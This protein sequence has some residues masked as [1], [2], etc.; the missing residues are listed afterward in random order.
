MKRS[1]FAK[2]ILAAALVA[3][4]SVQAASAV[5]ISEGS[6]PG[7]FSNG[8]ATPTT[9]A[10][11]NDVVTGTLTTGDRDYLAFTGLA[12]GAQT[13]T[14]S[15]SGAAGL[16]L[17]QGTVRYST[18]PFTSNTSGSNPGNIFLFA[19]FSA[20]SQTLSFSL[21]PTFAGALYLGLS[22]TSGQPISYSLSVPGNVVPAAVPLPASALLLGGAV[23]GMGALRRRAKRAAA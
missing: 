2:P 6:V 7:G 21:G 22:Q 4:A 1:G 17:S 9:I 11:G 19:F 3:A 13:I 15:F 18:S 12:A 14:L 10:N 23:A 20:P 16:Y 8:F 5:T